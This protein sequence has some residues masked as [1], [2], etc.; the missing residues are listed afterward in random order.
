MIRLL[1]VLFLAWSAVAAE[2]P[3]VVDATPYQDLIIKGREAQRKGLMGKALEAF[4]E[5]IK[6][7]SKSFAGYFFR[8]Q[9]LAAMR[10]PEEAIASFSKVIEL[11]PKA[12]SAYEGRA[13]E[14]FKLGQVDRSV[15]D[16]DRYVTLEPRRLPYEWQRG[17]ALYYAGKYEEGRK[18]F[19]LHQTV[20]PHDVENGV[21]HFLCVARESGFEKARQSILSINGDLRV[22]MPEVYEL[23]RGSGSVDDVL[24][25]CRKGNPSDRELESRMFYAHLY[26]GLYFEAKGDKEQTFEH[27]KAAATEFAQDDYM[28][29]VAKV[30]FKRLVGAIGAK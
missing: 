2:K 1:V 3:T 15:S 16:F 12:S 8:G 23:F 4:E 20:N 26:V 6:L 9:V 17:I 21:W 14:E 7:D 19:E 28:G 18:Q 24:K 25:A 10:K 11:D 27:I 5:A 13:E 30:H 29:D 22:P